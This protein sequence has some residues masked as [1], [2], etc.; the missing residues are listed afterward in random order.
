MA[1]IP[2]TP[3][4]TRWG[5]SEE[6]YPRGNWDPERYALETKHKEECYARYRE[7][8]ISKGADWLDEVKYQPDRRENR[9]EALRKKYP[10]LLKE[11][12]ERANE[13]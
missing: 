1:K 7:G 8:I 3:S 10:K 9:R 11:I 13:K 6:G 4:P 5:W 12:L 2:E